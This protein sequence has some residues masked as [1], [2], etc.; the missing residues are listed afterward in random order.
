MV[1]DI[2]NAARRTLTMLARGLGARQVQFDFGGSELVQTRL[3]FS[4]E[5]LPQQPQAQA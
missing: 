4:A 1:Q 5:P 3:D 2:Q